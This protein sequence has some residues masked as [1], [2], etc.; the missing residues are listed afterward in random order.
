MRWMALPPRYC[1]SV[2]GLNGIAVASHGRCQG[3]TRFRA[4]VQ[5]KLDGEGA[6]ILLDA[7]DEVSERGE[8]RDRLE[9][10]ARRRPGTRILV[11]S[12]VV[13]YETA[14]LPGTE[15]LVVLPFG[16]REI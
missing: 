4:F 13:G 3:A 7:W 5:R 12:R 14:P 16:R 2:V 9:S 11:A 15:E 1:P 10:F 8:L 6:V